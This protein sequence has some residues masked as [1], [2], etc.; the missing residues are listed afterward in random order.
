[1]FSK[2]WAFAS[3]TVLAT[4][5]S[6]GAASA[7]TVNG[8][9]EDSGTDLQATF[10]IST[11]LYDSIAEVWSFIVRITNIDLGEDGTNALTGFALASDPAIAYVSHMEM[12]ETSG[13][14]YEPRRFQMN[15]G[16]G[17]TYDFCLTSEGGPRG[18]GGTNCNGGEVAEGIMEG[19]SYVM[20]LIVEIS[21]PSLP[22]D[23]M[24]V[25]GRAA[26]RWQGV[27]PGDE[28]SGTGEGMS[29]V[30]LPAAGWMLIGALGGLAALRRRKAPSA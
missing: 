15:A 9:A 11:G 30:P 28:D 21:D 17:G 5:L 12:G 14:F 10:D 4:F 29:V 6:V 27:G 23:T 26:A 20:Q 3:A 25:F 24:P 2:L 1:M 22:P 13:T 16:V 19:S 8:F 18:E 7:I